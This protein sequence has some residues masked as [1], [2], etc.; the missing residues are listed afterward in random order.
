MQ[1]RIYCLVLCDRTFRCYRSK[2]D[3][4]GL[5]ALMDKRLT[6]AKHFTHGI[7]GMAVRIAS[8]P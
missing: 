5:D 4:D 8:P 2:Y 7:A 1:K 3:E 6:Q